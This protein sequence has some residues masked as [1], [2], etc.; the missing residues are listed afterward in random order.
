MP[1]AL[2]WNKRQAK[3]GQGNRGLQADDWV[4]RSF[5]HYAAGI[6][7]LFAGENCEDANSSLAYELIANDWRL[8]ASLNYLSKSGLPDSRV[9][10]N[11]LAS[12]PL[13]KYIFCKFAKAWLS[14]E[15]K[16]EP[17]AKYSQQTTKLFEVIGE[18]HGEREYALTIV[19]PYKDF[20]EKIEVVCE[21]LANCQ[22]LIIDNGA[23]AADEYEKSISCAAAS[24]NCLFARTAA[25]VAWESCIASALPLVRGERVMILDKEDEPEISGLRRCAMLERDADMLCFSY[26]IADGNN[27]INIVRPD[28]AVNKYE[29]ITDL[30]RENYSYKGLKA[31]GIRT[32]LLRKHCTG[33]H[34]S[35]DINILEL[36]N[37]CGQIHYS[38]INVLTIGKAESVQ[39]LPSDWQKYLDSELIKIQSMKNSLE[40]IFAS[41]IA[42]AFFTCALNCLFNDQKEMLFYALANVFNDPPQNCEIL[43][44]KIT[45]DRDFAARLLFAC[46]KNI[47]EKK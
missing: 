1:L 7:R 35:G 17:I 2:F 40:N 14:K 30:L 36:V 32:E 37:L 12:P 41:E 21:K 29:V 9:L 8:N 26:A 6:S 27:L 18:S 38:D 5:F 46:T 43:L 28:K 15:S 34:S 47:L 45:Q 20:L 25:P 13:L 22:I 31:R 42:A 19:T 4:C 44:G 11:L 39:L 10:T 23:M 24:T 3:A 16:Q 33:E